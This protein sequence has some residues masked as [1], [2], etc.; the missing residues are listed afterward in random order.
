MSDRSNND[1][2][3]LQQILQDSMPE[4]STE[5]AVLGNPKIKDIEI[6]GVT[7]NSK[8]VKPGNIFVAY[9]GTKTDAH[10]Y[11]DEAINLGAATIMVEHPEYLSKYKEIPCFQVSNGRKTL[12]KLASSFY[13]NPAQQMVVTGITGTNGKTTSTTLIDFI[14]RQLNQNSGLIGT[15]EHKINGKTVKA[16]ATTPPATELYRLLEQMN[17]QQVEY[18]TKEVSSHGLKQDRVSAINFNIAGITNI[19]RDHLDF[20]PTWQDYLASKTK[21]FQMLAPNSIAILNADESEAIFM[22]DK[23]RGKVITYGVR[24]SGTMVVAEQI[25]TTGFI[26]KFKYRITEEIPTLTNKAL[27]PQSHSVS[28]NMPG[29]HN[30]Y[31]SLLAITA[32]IAAGFPPE[33]VIEQAENFPGVF[34]RLEVIYK[35]D[36]TVIDDCAHNPSS[37]N[38]VFKTINQIDF[39]K[40]IILYAIRGNRGVD[41]NLDNSETLTK[42]V[43]QLPVKSLFITTCRSH[44]S[45]HNQV[46]QKEQQHFL[47]NLDRG[48]LSYQLIHDL[49]T[50]VKNALKSTERGDI[51]LILGPY[52]IDQGQNIVRRYLSA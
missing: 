22:G 3:K 42:W 41:I 1:G 11:I 20:H 10:Q 24:S 8:K 31:N 52:A 48:Q 15:V 50:A 19:S 2:V 49:E 5:F 36:F 14:L 34:R 46:T 38:S 29:T 43:K 25:S 21:I 39:N 12:T 47:S 27:T 17:Q 32:C 9:Q 40:L 28:I 35:N 7:N 6:T 33:K 44:C 51:M 26:T 37:L 23:T 16:E 18:V 4:L 13:S 30:I 45:K